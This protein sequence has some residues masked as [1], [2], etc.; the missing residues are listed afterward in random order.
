VST[1]HIAVRDKYVPL[2]DKHILTN[3]TGL[4]GNMGITN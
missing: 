1:P 4:K 2:C 3:V